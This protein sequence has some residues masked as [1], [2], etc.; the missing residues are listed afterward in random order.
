MSLVV[1]A[2][3]VG[4]AVYTVAAVRVQ[5]VGEM[6]VAVMARVA[7]VATWE[8]AVSRARAQALPN[9]TTAPAT[10]RAAV[11]AEARARP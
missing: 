2:E 5:A 9:S 1:A 10:A 6:E 4:A 8:K 7:V 3:K 11:I